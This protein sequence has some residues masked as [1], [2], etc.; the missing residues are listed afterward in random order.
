[1][2]VVEDNPHEV[3]QEQGSVEFL[4]GKGGCNVGGR[5]VASQLEESQEEEGS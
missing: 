4:R 1:M 3:V 5:A 2:R